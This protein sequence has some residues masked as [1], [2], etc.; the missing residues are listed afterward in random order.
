M[1]HA[2]CKSHSQSAILYEGEQIRWKAHQFMPRI[3]AF[4]A[5]SRA[6]FGRQTK[7]RKLLPLSF[8]FSRAPR[9]E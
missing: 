1:A 2:C 7:A 3:L 6:L 9:F 4:L 5:L 8:L